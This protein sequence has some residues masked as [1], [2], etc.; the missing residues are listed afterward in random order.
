MP[1]M[2]YMAIGK[3][4]SLIMV[5][6]LVAAS[7]MLMW[8][9]QVSAV[10]PT[11][12][13]TVSVPQY[14]SSPTYVNDLTTFS[15]STTPSI[16]SS[17]WYKWNDDAY[18]EYTGPFGPSIIYPV[19]GPPPKDLVGLHT[20]YYN[21]SNAGE[22]ETPKSL[23]IFVD[24]TFPVTSLDFSG[25]HH[26]GTVNYITSNTNITLSTLESG[27]GIDKV[28]YAIDDAQNIEYTGQFTISGTGSRTLNYYAIDNLGNQENKKSIELFIDNT[29]P[30]LDISMGSSSY[31]IDDIIYA[32]DHTDFTLMTSDDSGI[33]LVRYN[34]DGGLW[35]NYM[36]PF[37]LTQ[38]GSHV[39]NVEAIDNLGY[40]TAESMVLYMDN[41]P[42]EIISSLSFISNRIVDYGTL[43]YINVTYEDIFESDC[44]IYYSLDDESTWHEYENPIILQETC[45]ITYYAVDDLGNSS[46]I[47]TIE[48]TVNPQSNFM[49][50][51]G[52]WL[53]IA[54]VCS[55]L[56]VIINWDRLPGKK[57]AEP[58]KKN[59]KSGKK[60]SKSE[61]KAKKDN[62]KKSKKNKR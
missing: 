53:I 42:P 12:T 15:L 43:F 32:S 59:S 21:A 29:N 7:F 57:K 6:M 35:I 54:G 56:L 24:S 37:Y 18:K 27:C 20:L 22:H 46:P 30:T 31:A 50:S 10:V 4:C 14:G 38:D 34:V 26:E 41:S 33:S 51:Y 16:D 5:L 3:Q 44:K 40:S 55:I 48:V 8:V 61:I 17:I 2:I 13:L 23:E 39:L 9:P 47:E 62:R 52:M 1:Q 45:N 60:D 36:N 11:T 19:P 25:K 28:Y 58:K 49:K